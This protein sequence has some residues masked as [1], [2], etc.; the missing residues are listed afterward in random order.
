MATEEPIYRQ[1]RLY[2]ENGSI[3]A[4]Y[5]EAPGATSAVVWLGSTGGGLDSPAHDLYDRLAEELLQKQVSSIRFRYRQANDLETSIEDA[6]VALEFLEQRGTKTAMT[7]G[8]SFGGAVAIQ[9]GARSL[10]PRAVIGLASQSAGT[11]GANRISP[12]P[13]LLVHGA[14]DTVLPP[15]CS[16][17]IYE[18]A[19]EPKE[20]I[21][22]PGADHCFD[23]VAPELKTLLVGW[24]DQHLGL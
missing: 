8:F 6:L 7:V 3:A 23:N 24:I 2:L 22:L 13:L 21:I 10:L 16:A 15:E 1:V 11:D 18:R 9:A 4:R 12:R 17:L 20:L 14:E 5:Y 19:L